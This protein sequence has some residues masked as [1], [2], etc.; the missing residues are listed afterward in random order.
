MSIPMCYSDIAYTAKNRFEIHFIKTSSNRPP[1]AI[2]RFF[3]MLQNENAAI[4]NCDQ[5]G[6]AKAYQ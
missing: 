5:K 4:K 2:A 3:W 1:E 6:L